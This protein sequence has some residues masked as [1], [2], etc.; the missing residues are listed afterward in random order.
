M[1]LKGDAALLRRAANDL[2]KRADD[3]A[4]AEHRVSCGWSSS[5]YANHY[6]QLRQDAAALESLATRL[7]GCVPEM[8]THETLMLLSQGYT[9]Y[10]AS[11]K[12]SEY[13]R[14]EFLRRLEGEK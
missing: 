6:E 7:E 1:T 2:S 3:L 14:A 4:I 11:R 10:E 12:A 5:G 8:P 13:C 9:K